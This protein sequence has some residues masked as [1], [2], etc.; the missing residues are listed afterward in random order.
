M[1]AKSARSLRLTEVGNQRHSTHT[2]L[3]PRSTR[4]PDASIT[5]CRTTLGASASRRYSWWRPPRFGS[6]QPDVL[7]NGDMETYLVDLDPAILTSEI[8]GCSAIV[9]AGI[10]C[11]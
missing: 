4:R 10:A 6:R 11:S 2:H 7:A 1:P 9:E 8:C 5:G 3:G